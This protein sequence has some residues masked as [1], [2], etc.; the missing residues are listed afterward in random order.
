MVK[1]CENLHECEQLIPCFQSVVLNQTLDKA[2]DSLSDLRM[3]YQM[4]T[5]AVSRMWCETTGNFTYTDVLDRERHWESNM[6]T[7]FD[8]VH[9][10]ASGLRVLVDLQLPVFKQRQ[11]TLVHDAL[12]VAFPCV[13]LEMIH[14]YVW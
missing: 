10:H 9:G 12:R 2:L 6:S 14:A 7:M 4:K 3:Y 5:D 1:D 11:R 13:L 8:V